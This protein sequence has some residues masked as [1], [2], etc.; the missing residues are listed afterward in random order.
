M[1][2]ASDWRR[3][4][5]AEDVLPGAQGLDRVREAIGGFR[6]ALFED[7]RALSGDSAEVGRDGGRRQH[8]DKGNDREADSSDCGGDEHVIGVGDVE[9]ED[10]EGDVLE[11]LDV[12]KSG[13][14]EEREED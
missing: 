12:A 3:P 10:I 7:A 2:T 11:W 13:Q 6:E 14:S 5:L 9:A 1:R 4:I 8:E